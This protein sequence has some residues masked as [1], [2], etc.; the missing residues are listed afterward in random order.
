MLLANYLLTPPQLIQLFDVEFVV[1]NPVENFFLEVEGDYATADVRDWS[2][3]IRLMGANQTIRVTNGEDYM[4]LEIVPDLHESTVVTVEI[5]PLPV[6]RTLPRGSLFMQ[7]GDSA[8][9]SASVVD[10]DDQ[11][12]DIPIRWSMIQGEGTIEPE[13]GN[14]VTFTALSGG[15][16][17][18]RGTAQF[19]TT[20][21]VIHVP[22]DVAGRVVDIQGRGVEDVDVVFHNL[23]TSVQTDA[24]GYWEKT[25]V[26]GEVRASALKEGW[27]FGRGYLVL[28]RPDDELEFRQVDIG[29]RVEYDILGM[30]VAMRLAPGLSFPMGVQNVAT[31]E[32]ENDFWIAETP[33]TYELWYSVRKWALENGYTFANVGREGSSGANGAPPTSRRY[34]PVTRISWRDAVVWA[35]ALSEYQGFQPV[36]VNRG[37]V[38]RDALDAEAVDNVVAL[39]TDG[40]RLPTSEEWEL[41]ARYQGSDPWAGAL[42]FPRDSGHFWTPGHY[43]SGASGHH[44]DVMATRA[45]AWFIEN[46]GEKTQPVARKE[47]NQLGLY[48]MSGNVLEW[49]F[50]ADEASR[51]RRGGAWLYNSSYLQVG[52]SNS[53]DPSGVYNHLGFRLVRTP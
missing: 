18:L 3:P 49:C 22:Y 20:D 48:D 14:E 4:D 39:D 19:S 52:I 21:I 6:I 44:E 12:V 50:T 42:E 33:V 32:V 11:V 15:V 25:H 46:S 5:P 51:I 8:L 16:H 23:L 10:V 13:E 53:Y 27:L 47:P 26:I 34:E 7:P 36:Y 43:A 24:E 17:V 40:F 29:D 1:E 35:N 28:D 2:E 37:Q 41:A 31:G 45:V 9:I 30:R 38:L